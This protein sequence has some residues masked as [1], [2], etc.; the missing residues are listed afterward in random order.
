LEAVGADLEIPDQP[1]PAQGEFASNEAKLESKQ[2]KK[3][4]PDILRD[5]SSPNHLVHCGAQTLR[6]SKPSAPFEKPR[7]VSH[8]KIQT[9]REACPARVILVSA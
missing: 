2:V 7:R 4:S 3:C 1:L 6:S 8:P 5:S 9:R